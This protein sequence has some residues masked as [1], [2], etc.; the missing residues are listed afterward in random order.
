[1]ERNGVPQVRSQRDDTVC[2]E[3]TGKSNQRNCKLMGNW[4][5]S[6]HFIN[7]GQSES[8]HAMF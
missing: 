1:M 3:L 8:F 7:K 5:I 4:E 2:I 6:T